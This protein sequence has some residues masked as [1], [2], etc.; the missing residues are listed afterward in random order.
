MATTKQ[1]SVPRTR[2]TIIMLVESNSEENFS[3]ER[4]SSIGVTLTEK[5]HCKTIFGN[6]KIVKAYSL[7]DYCQNISSSITS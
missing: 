4:A 1:I 3:D 5:Q 2:I 7:L 6:I